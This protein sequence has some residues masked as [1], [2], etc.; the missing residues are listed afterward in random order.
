MRELGSGSI[1]G[2][3]GVAPARSDPTWRAQLE[4]VQQALASCTQEIARQARIQ[5]SIELSGSL[6]RSARRLRSAQ[7]DDWREALLD[8]VRDFCARAALFTIRNA[9]LHLEG[10]RDLPGERRLGDCPLSA[11][12]AFRAAVDTGDTVI[13]MRTKGEM[14]E[15]I[16]SRFGEAQDARFHLFPISARGKVA[17]VLYA[18]GDSVQVECLDLLA[19]VAGAV[20]E[21]RAAGPEKKTEFVNI[22]VARKEPAAEEWSQLSEEE[23]E[24]HRKAQRFGRVQ[25]ASLRLYKSDDV[26]TARAEGTLYKS[27]KLE[28]DAARGVFRRDFIAKSPTM[29][30]Y[31]HLELVRTLA[32]D[33][34]ELLGPDYPGPM[35]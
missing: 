33:N 26:K 21:S 24:L 8:A 34:V 22:A 12:P 15:A 30:D 23:R 7:G 32:N 9:S 18:D 19:C 31:F 16:A 27:L 2:A 13:A 5:A 17:A 28:I 3:P 20:L 11:A 4:P 35:V 1:G 29:V 14:S 10:S 25:V 6:N